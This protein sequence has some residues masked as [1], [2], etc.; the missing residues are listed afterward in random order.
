MKHSE[1]LAKPIK[2]K[3]GGTINF[4]G[5]SKHIKDKEVGGDINI[6]SALLSTIQDAIPLQDKLVVEND[7]CEATVININEVVAGTYYYLLY[8][9]ENLDENKN[10]IANIM[11]N[12]AY[13]PYF[14]TNAVQASSDNQNRVT[15]DGKE[16]VYL[17]SSIK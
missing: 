6:L 3:A 9:P 2:T 11:A 7:D 8:E 12:N 4:K 15:I 17:K 16:Y 13:E 1:I 10:Y 14:T 5:L